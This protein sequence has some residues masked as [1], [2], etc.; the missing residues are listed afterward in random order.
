MTLEIKFTT[1]FKRDVKLLSKQHKNLDLLF[2]TIEKL[3]NMETLDSK[4]K[5]HN[6]SGDFYGCREC[7]IE[8]DF[9]LIYEIHNDIMVLLLVRTG[10]HSNLFK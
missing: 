2:D 1:Q 9:L 8:L 5:D 4:Y 3:A 6:L 10:S 7:H